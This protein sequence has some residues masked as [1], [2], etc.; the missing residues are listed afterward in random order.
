M[1]KRA[2]LGADNSQSSA[3]QDVVDNVNDS[4]IP[5]TDSEDEGLDTD[6]ALDRSGGSS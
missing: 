6:D 4:D 1:S 2:G 5:P 3:S